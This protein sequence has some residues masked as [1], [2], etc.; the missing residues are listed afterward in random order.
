M[1]NNSQHLCSA[2]PFPKC[3]YIHNSF[4]AH[5]KKSIV[6]ITTV[7]QMKKLGPGEVE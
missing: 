6:I 5:N 2:L 7:L 3:F 1:N 4:Y